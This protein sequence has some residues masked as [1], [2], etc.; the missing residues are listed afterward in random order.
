[1]ALE[2]FNFFALGI[3]GFMIGREL[4][5]DV[6]RKY[7]RQFVAILFSEGLGAF[8]ITSI[9]ATG[10]LLLVTRNIAASVATGIVLGGL[11]S[12]SR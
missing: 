7:G 9:L 1:M 10:V 2:P 5:R 6:F 12:A 11:S 4:H 3:I 8:A